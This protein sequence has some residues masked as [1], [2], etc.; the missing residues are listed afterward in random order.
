MLAENLAAKRSQELETLKAKLEKR[1]HEDEKA[2]IRDKAMFEKVFGR[3]P[4]QRQGDDKYISFMRSYENQRERLEK[5]C[6]ALE[7]EL[8]RVNSRSCELESQNFALQKGITLTATSRDPEVGS[9]L[10]Q[11]IQQRA[12]DLE[13]ENR[14]LTEALQKMQVD[15]KDLLKEIERQRSLV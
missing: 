15:F 11:V 1:L 8:D 7:R 9:Y 10:D 12:H 2:V 5:H 14:K 4:S 3:A 6:E 13:A